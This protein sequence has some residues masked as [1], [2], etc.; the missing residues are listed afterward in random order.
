MGSPIRH[1]PIDRFTGPHSRDHT[2]FI[3]STDHPRP[4]D[5]TANYSRVCC[6][7][8]LHT[9]HCVLCVSHVRNSPARTSRLDA[10]RSLSRQLQEDLEAALD[11]K[12]ALKEEVADLTSALEATRREAAGFRSQLAGK[13][14]LLTQ[15][16]GEVC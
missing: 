16:E 13:A 4:R 11:R 5:N 14:D 15:V 2:C 7:F 3:A 8:D 10:E 9:T 6:L 12:T 1:R